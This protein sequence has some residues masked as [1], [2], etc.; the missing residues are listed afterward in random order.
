MIGRH[1]LVYSSRYPR[2]KRHYTICSTMAEG[3]ADLIKKCE[4][5]VVDGSLFNPNLSCIESIDQTKINLTLK[6]YQAKNG[7]ATQL[8]GAEVLDKNEVFWIKGP[9]G[10]GLELDQ[11]STGHHFAFCAGT[12]ILIFLDIVSNMIIANT[13]D[14]NE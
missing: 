14:N 4:N 8:H 1:F 3:V 2:I 9:M 5:A 6:N 10:K 12:A 13:F 7:V 11:N